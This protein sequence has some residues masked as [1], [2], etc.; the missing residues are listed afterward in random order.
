M[1]SRSVKK[2]T[3]NLIKG[4]QPEPKDYTVSCNSLELR[5]YVTGTKSWSFG[6]RYKGK[7]GRLKIGRYPYISIA[8]A[9]EAVLDARKLL[10]NDIEPSEHK[11]QVEEA[12]QIERDTSITVNDL[13]HLWFETIVSRTLRPRS[14]EDYKKDVEKHVLSKWGDL[15]V[16]SITRKMGKDLL[17]A[18]LD[19]GQIREADHVKSNLNKMWALAIEE[20]VIEAHPFVGIKVYAPIEVQEAKHKTNRDLNRAL[21]DQEIYQFW[22]GSIKYCKPLP[23]AALRLM[24]LLGR[25]GADVR[26]MLKS[27]IDI[28]R[29]VWHMIPAKVKK[30]ELLKYKPVIMPL[31]PLAFNIIAE[32]M[33]ERSKVDLMFPSNDISCIGLP[34]TQSALSQPVT[35][36]NR[37]DIAVSWTPH[38]LRKTASTGM[39]ELGVDQPTINRVLAHKLDKLEG[40]YNKNSFINERL[41]ALTQWNDHIFRIISGPAPESI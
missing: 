34:I 38:D 28:D 7:K 40:T 1:A 33:T 21:N 20:N 15:P 37:F 16:K 19:K 14:I 27:E 35:R 17:Q 13:Y 30:S 9:N 32:L 18:M 22:Y 2:F 11:K 39:S 29:K 36:H 5:V 23:G 41:D 10:A 26:K 24:L 25:R 3:D 6:Y 31:P 12:A 8:E 4:L